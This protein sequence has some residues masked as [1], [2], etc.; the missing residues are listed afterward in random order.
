MDTEK[1][2]KEFNNWG[3]QLRENPE[4]KI[5]RVNL[6]RVPDII[7]GRRVFI[8][9]ESDAHSIWRLDPKRLIRCPKSFYT[10][11]RSMFNQKNSSTAL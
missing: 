2:E 9:P 8:A 6:V 10:R 3:D 7:Q 1:K 5:A 11:R 4:Q